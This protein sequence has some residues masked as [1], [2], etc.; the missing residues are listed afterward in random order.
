MDRE[1]A[2]RAGKTS[3]EELT[4]EDEWAYCIAAGVPDDLYWQL[5]PP[6][7]RALLN[8]LQEREDGRARQLALAAG[9]VAAEIRNSQRRRGG[10]FW[11]P[12]DFVRAR[13]DAGSR[14]PTAEEIARLEHRMAPTR[15]IRRD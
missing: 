4:P 8:A 9:L 12:E 1:R 14:A 7:L 15:S 5:T 2:S 13:G 3:G 6:E 10:R 11:R